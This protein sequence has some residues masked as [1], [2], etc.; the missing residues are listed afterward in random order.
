MSTKKYRAHLYTWENNALNKVEHFFEDL[1]EAIEF[2]EHSIADVF[3]VFDEFDILHH[4]GKHH[5]HH[6]YA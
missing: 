3:K 4:H 6:G 1:N 5:H 2:C